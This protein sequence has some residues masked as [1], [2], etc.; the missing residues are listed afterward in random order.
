VEEAGKWAKEEK[1]QSKLKINKSEIYMKV[2][3]K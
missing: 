1:K 3:N 2:K